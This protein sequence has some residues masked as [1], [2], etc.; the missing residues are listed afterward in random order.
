MLSLILVSVP[1]GAIADM[2]DQR[3]IAMT[4]L[5]FASLCAVALTTLSCFGLSSPWLLLSFCP[6]ALSRREN[7]KGQLCTVS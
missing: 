2:F 1:G 6:L 5:G 7:A 3:R 4:G